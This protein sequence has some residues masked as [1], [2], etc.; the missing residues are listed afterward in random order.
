MLEEVQST[1]LP[2]RSER[3]LVFYDRVM[4]S[5]RLVVDHSSLNY[6]DDIGSFEHAERVMIGAFRPNERFIISILRV[7]EQRGINIRRAYYDLF[8]HPDGD[9]CMMSVY[10]APLPDL[11]TA[12]C[13]LEQELLSLDVLTVKADAETEHL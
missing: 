3:H 1:L 12:V 6:E 4:D 2:K 10:F 13:G 7:F 11:S 8:R 9:V 5:G